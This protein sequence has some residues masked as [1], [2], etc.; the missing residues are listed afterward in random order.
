M[1]QTGDKG[2]KGEYQCY[3][4][5]TVIHINNDEVPLPKCPKCGS[6]VFIKLR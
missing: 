1:Y 5:G 3:N 2:G 6:E 4:C